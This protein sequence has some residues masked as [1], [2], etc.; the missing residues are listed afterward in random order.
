MFTTGFKFFFGLFAAFCVA[1]LVYGYTTGGDH[2]GPLSLGWKGGVGD[3]IGYGLLV[4]LA[5]VS[6]TISL[7]LVSFRDA[8]AAA[9]AQLQNVAEVLTDQ[10]VAASFWP[11]VA[12]FGVG[13]AAVGLV[14]HPMV[15][16]LGLALVT[17]SLVEWTMDAWADRATGDTTVNRELRNRIMAPIEI[18]VIGTLAV[19]VIVLAA[20]RILLTVSQLEA[21]TVAGV[22]SALILGGA[23]VYAS[24]PGLG[25]RLVRIFGTVGA[26]L[27][28]V[29][30]V[31]AAVAGE[32]DFHHHEDET[33]EESG[34]ESGEPAGTG[35]HGG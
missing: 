7:V 23:W 20:S 32:R 26:L 27:L 13:A 19:G 6:L 11:V 35:E 33:H 9:Q 25:R 21:V 10:P 12:S 8:D 2:V 24:R 31:L 29:G 16:V 5:G 15:F 30:G 18:P 22:V 17:L 3:H 28:L 14:L 1:A 34:D 4:A